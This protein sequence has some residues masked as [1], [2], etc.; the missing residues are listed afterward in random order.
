MRLGKW[1]FAKLDENIKRK[2]ILIALLEYGS[3]KYFL[4]FIVIVSFT[5]GVTEI[6]IRK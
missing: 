1:K 3:L 4:Q 6:K 5:H 2:Y